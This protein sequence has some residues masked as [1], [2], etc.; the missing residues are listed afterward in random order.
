[1]V[2]VLMISALFCNVTYALGLKVPT[3][4]KLGESDYMGDSINYNKTKLGIFPGL[5]VVKYMAKN[6][7]D[8]QAYMCTG[9]LINTAETQKYYGLL[10]SN[11]CLELITN[12]YSS[13]KNMELK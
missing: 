12:K 6:K 11:H 9:V 7:G 10:T 3:L 4:A 5:L 8:K 2:M 1:M 13:G